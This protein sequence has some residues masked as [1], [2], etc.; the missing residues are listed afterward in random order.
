MESLNKKIESAGLISSFHN[1]FKLLLK[2]IRI[3][4]I[5]CSIVCCSWPLFFSTL[6]VILFT[7]IPF[8]PALVNY[9]GKVGLLYDNKHKEDPPFNRVIPSI[10]SNET[11]Q[12][13]N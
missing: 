8:L 1:L 3:R 12:C 5:R 13:R 6:A 7:V 11:T 4:T 10:P 9:I 2:K